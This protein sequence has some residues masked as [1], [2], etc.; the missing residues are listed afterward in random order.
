MPEGGQHIGG[1][2]VVTHGA[3]RSVIGPD[4]VFTF[5]RAGTCTVQLSADDLGISRVAGSI[6]RQGGTWW[7]VNRSGSRPLSVTDDLGLRTVVA[8]GHRVSVTGPLTVV[9]EGEAHRHAIA[10]DTAPSRSEVPVP[11]VG[12][13]RPTATAEGVLLDDDDR[14]ALVAVFAGYLRDF[15]RYDPHPRSYT[16]AAAE[17]GWPRTTLLKRMERIRRRLTDAGVTNLLGDTALQHLAD[18]ALATRA[19]SRDDLENLRRG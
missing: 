19:I 8:P 15:P 12:D 4:E 11:D 5:G 10:L 14:R 17:L 3:N 2:V 7:L 18:W 16:E 9:V 1:E 13:R 6:E